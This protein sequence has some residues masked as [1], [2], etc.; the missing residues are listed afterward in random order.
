M[1]ISMTKIQRKYENF[2]EI[3]Y[4]LKKQAH[5]WYSLHYRSNLQLLAQKSK[6]KNL[7]VSL[8]YYCCC[9]LFTAIVI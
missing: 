7:I 4:C 2:K 1:K 9:C 6:N 3:K 8:I 5:R